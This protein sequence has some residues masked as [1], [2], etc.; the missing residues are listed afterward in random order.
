MA[1]TPATAK[2]E[3]RGDSLIVFFMVFLSGLVVLWYRCAASDFGIA[4][5]DG[6]QLEGTVRQ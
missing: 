1:K 2:L 3:A 6:H 4:E 5:D